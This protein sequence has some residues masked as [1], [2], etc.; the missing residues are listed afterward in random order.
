MLN[1]D[2]A[3]IIRHKILA[4]EDGEWQLQ[5]EG[6]IMRAKLNSVRWQALLWT[7]L[8]ESSNSED[9]HSQ[10]TIFL[11]TCRTRACPHTLDLWPHGQNKVL[12]VRFESHQFKVIGLKRGEWEAEFGLQPPGYRKSVDWAQWKRKFHN[13]GNN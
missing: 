4:H 11:N 7:S 6:G 9:P 8:I 10:L 1:I 3:V 13:G 12:S 2:R 5:Y